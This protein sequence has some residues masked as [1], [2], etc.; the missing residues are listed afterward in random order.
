LAIVC[1]RTDTVE[2][3]RSAGRHVEVPRPNCPTCGEP[4]TFSSG[5][6]RD[7][8][9]PFA[10]EAGADRR[11]RIWIRR[12]YCRHC[13]SAPGILPSFCLSRRLDVVEVVGTV[14][15]AVAGG[16]PVAVAAEEQA[17]PRSTA[18]GWISR[19][20]E[21]APGIANRFA[22]LAIDLGSGPFSLSSRPARAA[23]E[24]VGRAL[25]AAR[26]KRAGNVV[27]VWRFVSVVSGGA[28]LATNK[29]PP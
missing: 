7:V 28:L 13:R 18:R 19:F 9:T 3:Y 26:R 16:A 27:G 8:R 25:Q 4:M 20:A 17:I 29:S 23:V 1:A 15:A 14:I 24:A 10:P 21:R 5:Y 11:Q 12:A 22:S 6:E 2:E